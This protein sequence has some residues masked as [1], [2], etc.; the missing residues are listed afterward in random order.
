VP[1]AVS[2]IEINPFRQQEESVIF[3]LL[4][5]DPYSTALVLEEFG[6]AI[7]RGGSGIVIASM[8]GYRL[9]AL[10]PE[11][12]EAL[13]MPATEELLAMPML[14][15]DCMTNPPYAYQVSKRGNALRVRAEAV[16]WGRRGARINTIS[17]GLI[18]MPLSKGEL[19]GLRGESYRRMTDRCAA[20]RAGTPDEVGA[21][22]IFDGTGW[23]LHH[24]PRFPDGRWR[25]CGLLVRRV[26]PA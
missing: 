13:A 1:P 16:R 8:S 19:N 4:S 18:I 7:A 22:C 6:N 24:R 5:V 20:R 9:P 26:H 25:D 2:Q 11:Q 21:R 14:Q 15:P 12:D 23:Q 17:P 3:L 10:T